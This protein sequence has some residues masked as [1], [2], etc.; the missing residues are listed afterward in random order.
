[1]P[2]R[3]QVDD[4]IRIDVNRGDSTTIFNPVDVL[5]DPS[6]DIQ[7]PLLGT[8][9]VEGKTVGE[10]YEYLKSHYT[11]ELQLQPGILRLSVTTVRV[12]QI[13]ASVIGA[14][15][16]PGIFDL[17]RGDRI[18]TLLANAQGALMDGSADL[19]RG[20]LR[21]AKSN[22][23]IPLDLYD[24]LTKGDT[25]QD[26]A[27]QDGDVVTIPIEIRNR[28]VIDGEVKQP[29]V[30]P[31]AEGISVNQAI[32]RAG[33]RTDLSRMTKVTVIR[34]RPG[35]P[36]D[37]EYITVDLVAFYKG[38]DRTQNIELKPGDTVFVPT[39]GNPNLNTI[40]SYFNLIFLFRTLGFNP[41][42]F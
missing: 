6:G 30:I 20:T 4:V 19:H 25:T 31:Y 35:R 22:E 3:L 41:F 15:N 11:T 28:I 36:D 2:Y 39:N 9:H 34:L 10:V 33:G 1:G 7:A 23:V 42:S 14:V 13:R 37:P 40:N 17:K 27:V 38:K 16:K 29:T 18:S 5:V 26:Y 24:L 21:R 12:H 32:T 8:V